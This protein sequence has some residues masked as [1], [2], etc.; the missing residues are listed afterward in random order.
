MYDEF[1]KLKGFTPYKSFAN[2]MLV[3]IP[4]EIRKE[5]KEYLNERNLLI[6]FLDEEAFR[7]EARI[8][9]GTHKENK[10]LMNT[11]KKFCK[12]KSWQ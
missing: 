8:S 3:D 6:K 9:L 4:M 5:L 11:I 10:L 2:F 1:F 7:S 12:E